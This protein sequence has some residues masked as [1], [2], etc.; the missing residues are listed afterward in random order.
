MRLSWIKTQGLFLWVQG[1]LQAPAPAL[2]REAKSGEKDLQALMYCCI[3]VVFM[4]PSPPGR[5]EVKDPC[6][7]LN[8]ER[9]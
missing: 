8:V 9:G 3:L 2:G 6:N 1:C 5:V 7:V 4:C